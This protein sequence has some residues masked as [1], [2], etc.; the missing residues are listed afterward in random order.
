MKKI[1]III[2]V[3]AIAFVIY[4]INNPDLG[5]SWIWPK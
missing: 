5:N 1:I 4:V 3:L 2:I